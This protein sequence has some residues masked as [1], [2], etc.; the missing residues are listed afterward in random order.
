MASHPVTDSTQRQSNAASYASEHLA[1]DLADPVGTAKAQAPRPDAGRL[2][3]DVLHPAAPPRQPSPLTVTP[4]SPHEAK[5]EPPIARGAKPQWYIGDDWTS[6]LSGMEMTSRAYPRRPVDAATL[7]Q[8]WHVKLGDVIAQHELGSYTPAMLAEAL[9]ALYTDALEH[10]FGQAKYQSGSDAAAVQN[11]QAARNII[12]GALKRDA[13]VAARVLCNQHTA[14]AWT[15]DSSIAYQLRAAAE[16]ARDSGISR[17][18]VEQLLHFVEVKTPHPCQPYSRAFWH[19]RQQLMGQVLDAFE[20]KDASSFQMISWN[21]RTTFR[22]LSALRPE[23]LQHRKTERAAASHDAAL[24]EQSAGLYAEGATGMDAS[25]RVESTVTQVLNAVFSEQPARPARIKYNVAS[26]AYDFDGRDSGSDHL[27]SAL[28]STHTKAT[29]R[30]YLHRLDRI[31]GTLRRM[32]A[33]PE[34]AGDRALANALRDQCIAFRGSLTAWE[35]RAGHHAP[36]DMASHE[37]TLFAHVAMM[38]STVHHALHHA[39]QHTEQFALAGENGFPLTPECQ[40]AARDLLRD[41][42]QL[43]KACEK[44]QLG[45]RNELRQESHIVWQLA[46]NLLRDVYRAETGDPQASLPQGDAGLRWI[47]AC[48]QRNAVLSNDVI[49]AKIASLRAEQHATADRTE[50]TLLDKQSS[51]L[52]MLQTFRQSRNT[53]IIQQVVLSE[54]GGDDAP[55]EYLAALWLIRAMGLSHTAI[56]PLGETVQTLHAIPE[57]LSTISTACGWLP[58]KVRMMVALSDTSKRAGSFACTAA[59]AASTARMVDVVEAYNLTH[60]HHCDVQ[61]MLGGGVSSARG[62]MDEPDE[63]GYPHL[64]A[65]LPPNVAKHVTRVTVQGMKHLQWSLDARVQSDQ[66]LQI[67]AA[68]LTASSRAVPSASSEAS[69]DV[70]AAQH[71]VWQTIASAQAQAQEALTQG[72]LLQSLADPDHTRASTDWAA[73]FDAIFKHVWLTE[74]VAASSKPYSTRPGAR[75][76]STKVSTFADRRAIGVQSAELMGAIF[77]IFVGM[78]RGISDVYRSEHGTDGTTPPIEQNSSIL[79]D[80]YDPNNTVWHDP[81][82]KLEIDRIQSTLLLINWDHVRSCFVEAA[83][84]D[85]KNDAYLLYRHLRSEASALI[86]WVNFIVGQGT[87]LEMQHHK[88][89]HTLA[90]REAAAPILGKLLALQVQRERLITADERERNSQAMGLLFLEF[91]SAVGHG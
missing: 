27:T 61:F 14:D 35:G 60:A 24:E 31:E 66:I 62:V 26:W 87:L 46:I 48:I 58:S 51:F 64:I 3:P 73:K 50:K 15:H 68:K 69:A 89:A 74:A 70:R 85:D 56:C 79:K 11:I 6:P 52:A 45:V 29:V 41:V 18:D 57:A 38:A 53:K 90:Q 34:H 78:T 67:F 5:R 13:A 77:T 71:H 32:E 7:Q 63:T 39:R 20:A 23:T 9:H 83:P 81:L 86:H 55:Q 44:H 12:L 8:A 16:E 47:S 75:S 19:L 2:S 40:S 28:L 65:S 10:L 84:A 91:V 4:P 37:H 30:A 59:M 22:D 82:F 76:D 49:D 36:T 1:T 17:D 88:R 80:M 42:A 21:M 54:F 43:Q 33:L 25:H 72:A